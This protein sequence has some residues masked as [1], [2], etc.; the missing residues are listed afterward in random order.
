MFKKTKTN[1]WSE[2]LSII[3]K[4]YDVEILNIIEKYK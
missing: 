4:L 1:D 3:E 2:E